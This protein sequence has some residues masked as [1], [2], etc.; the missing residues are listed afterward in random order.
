MEWILVNDLLQYQQFGEEITATIL[1]AI[2]VANFVDMVRNYN[3]QP[4]C[5][6]DVFSLLLHFIVVSCV[7]HPDSLGGCHN[8]EPVRQD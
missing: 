6:N 8:M 7:G 3:H 2:E 4:S 1:R 5:I